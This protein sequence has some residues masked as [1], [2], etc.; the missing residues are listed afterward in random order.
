MQEKDSIDVLEELD[1]GRFCS[2]GLLLTN[3][4]RSNVTAIYLGKDKDG[5]YDFYDG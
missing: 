3:S 1:K 5:R 4:M 2:I